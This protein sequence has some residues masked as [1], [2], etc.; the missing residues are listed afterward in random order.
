LKRI[1]TKI[2]PV[3]LLLTWIGAMAGFGGCAAKP[4][5]RYNTPPEDAP[6]QRLYPLSAGAVISSTPA[7][8]ADFV[9]GKIQVRVPARS[10]EDWPAFGR[11][12]LQDPLQWLE[13]Q[14]L[15]NRQRLH[16]IKEVIMPLALLNKEHQ[17]LALAQIFPN[18][19]LTPTG[20][21]HVVTH[22]G[23]TIWLIA[24]IFTGD[25]NNYPAIQKENNL[26]PES[27]LRHEQTVLISPNLLLPNL[28]P[29]NLLVAATTS[30]PEVAP[31]SVTEPIKPTPELPKQAASNETPSSKPST[32]SAAS[33]VRAPTTSTKDR[34]A[35]TPAPRDRQTVAAL[36]HP[37]L[38][39]QQN[40]RGERE[41]VYRL[42]KGEALYSAVVVR[43]TGRIDADEV[44]SIAQKLLAYNGLSDATR[45]PD[46]A[47]I[48]I[49]V[50]FLDEDI[51]RGKIPPSPITRPPR[52]ERRS[53][54]RSN[55]H[56]ILDAG[57]GGNDPGTI[58]R[59]WREDEIAY[60]LMLRIK[61]GL[62]NRGA[63]VY[64][65]VSDRRTG[66][67]VNGGSLLANNREE[68]VKVTPE[69]FMDDSRIALNLRIYLIEDLYRWILRRGAAP[70]NVVMISIHLDHL[71]PSVG[72]AMVY[73][74]GA[75]QRSSQ[76]KA[77]GSVYRQFKESRQGAIY[78]KR[79]ESASAEE[80]SR[81][82][83]WGLIDAFQK[84]N[85]PVHAY[86]PVRRYVYRRDSKW[87]PGIIRYSRVPTSILLEAANLSN[88]DDLS[89]IR[90]A[91]FRQRLAE[92]VVKT[93][94]AQE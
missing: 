33:R 20:W 59:G 90:S 60:E 58:M 19:E 77:A 68:Y 67:T 64:S 18:D 48:R 93:I 85:I 88:R 8:S 76:F 41:A 27:V 52:P 47:L 53:R 86:Q 81:G 9:E 49:P 37:D 11:R 12:V 4:L 2:L 89:R 62:Q 31:P 66:D 5:P 24:E 7:L 71:H 54:T 14:R 51:L 36:S 79:S 28:R 35:R 91:S 45:I 70:E 1:S 25:G 65:T 6:K 78:F 75:D 73:F 30:L 34:T 57:H 10:G 80:A 74:P 3:L 55:L 72:G 83:A 63:K 56:V 32:P 13:V 69:Y 94:M 21:R 46:G 84:T 40:A 29:A 82:F 22:S 15:N 17:R 44:S 38:V 42:K 43:F 92:A 61:Q 23:E 87:T 50:R 16:S 26:A 39:F